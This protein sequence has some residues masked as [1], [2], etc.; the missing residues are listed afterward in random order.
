MLLK[1]SCQTQQNPL[2]FD[3]YLSYKVNKFWQISEFWFASDDCQVG[4]F[5]LGFFFF[6]FKSGSGKYSILIKKITHFI[7]CIHYDSVL[8]A[9][10]PFRW[11]S[12]I[13]S[14]IRKL[15]KLKAQGLS[16]M[17]SINLSKGLHL[18]FVFREIVSLLQVTNIRALGQLC[19]NELG[20]N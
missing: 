10:C 2:I 19:K 6:Y 11:H 5:L 1:K 14:T 4:E 13:H 17:P 20:K 16:P 7:S 3:D 18:Y 9:V 12:K 15:S 8:F